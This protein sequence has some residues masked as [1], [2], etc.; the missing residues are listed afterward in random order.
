MLKVPKYIYFFS[1]KGY[2]LSSIE[3]R[4]AV[5]YLDPSPEVQKRKYAFKCHRNKDGDVEHIFPVNA[6]SFHKEYNTFATG[7]SDGK[8]PFNFENSHFMSICLQS[9]KYVFVRE[10]VRAGAAGAR[11]RRSLGHHLLHPLI[12]RLLVLCAP[13]DFEAQSSLL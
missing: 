10:C 12:L 13:A 1:R 3:G 5:E 4:V 8:S 11:T 9:I 2:V 7:G 6:I